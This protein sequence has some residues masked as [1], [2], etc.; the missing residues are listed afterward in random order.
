MTEAEVLA[1]ATPLFPNAPS[2]VLGISYRDD[3]WVVTFFS[4]SGEVEGRVLVDSAG[5]AE[6]YA[7]DPLPSLPGTP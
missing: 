5:D 6:V 3:E 7:P 1:A 4:V 2:D